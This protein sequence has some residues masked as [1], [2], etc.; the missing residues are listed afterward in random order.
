MGEQGRRSSRAA[1]GES[2]NQLTLSL[3]GDATGATAVSYVGHSGSGPWVTN[4][5]GVG[6]LT[7]T[8]PISAYTSLP[9][10]PTN[11]VGNATPLL[12][13]E[14]SWQAVTLLCP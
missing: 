2:G 9:A 8:I 6:L 7:F 13:A 11:L 14:L 12:Q 1:V 3:S 4:V 5:L 10:T